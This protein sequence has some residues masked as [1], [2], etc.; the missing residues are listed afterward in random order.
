MRMARY[1]HTHAADTRSNDRHSL[2]CHANKC[3]SD[4]L[5]DPAI[6]VHLA[7]P[8]LAVNRR[9]SLPLTDVLACYVL[10]PHLR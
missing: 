4:F 3:V 8:F 2:S 10:N 6:S 9:D 5:H 7:A 1:Y